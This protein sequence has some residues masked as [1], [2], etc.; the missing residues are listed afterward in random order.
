MRSPIWAFLA[1]IHLNSADDF[2]WVVAE[3]VSQL[4]R[5][6]LTVNSSDGLWCGPSG[7]FTQAF[8]SFSNYGWLPGEPGNSLGD[9][10]ASGDNIG[11]ASVPVF[12]CLGTYTVAVGGLE[13]A[14]ASLG[15]G[16]LTL[17]GEGEFLTSTVSIYG[18]PCTDVEVCNCLSCDAAGAY[19]DDSKCPIGTSALLL[20]GQLRRRE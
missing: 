18:Q 19:G 2:E 5:T 6:V 13:L 8:G 11:N 20:S 3:V 17:H 7:C 1:L 4:N 10:G 14:A 16:V 12:A 15:G 9:G